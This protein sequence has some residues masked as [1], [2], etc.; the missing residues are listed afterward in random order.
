MKLAEALARRAELKARFDELSKRA[1]GSA[2]IQEGDTP[3]EDPAELL[4]EADRV[5][6]EFERLI[7]QINAT[8]LATEVVPGMTMT[9]ALAQRDVLRMR[10]RIRVSVADAGV[11]IADR[12]TRSE[13]KMVPTVG[14]RE[15]RREADTM[16]AE[17]RELDT[18]MQEVNWTA[19]LRE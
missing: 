15:L 19:E 8:N 4:A 16:A 18:R 5:A 13:I 12:W 9:D 17:L 2:R 6:D 7:R 14:V 1:A 3:A 10:R 11:P